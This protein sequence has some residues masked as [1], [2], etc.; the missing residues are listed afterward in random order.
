M[1]ERECSVQ[2][3]EPLDICSVC[4]W[5]VHMYVCTCVYLFA[6]HVHMCLS[7]H[8]FPFFPVLR[9]NISSCFS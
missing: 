1:R 7:R 2:L 5:C 9:I 8:K 4:V 3:N 6:V